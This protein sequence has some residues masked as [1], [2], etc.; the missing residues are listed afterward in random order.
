[1][2]IFVTCSDPKFIIYL[3]K[4]KYENEDLIKY[5]LPTDIWFHV[6]KFSSAHVYLRLPP[7]VTIDKIPKQVMSECL[8][9]VKDGSKDGRKQEKVSVVYTPWYNL[10]KTQGMEIGEVGFKNEKDVHHIQNVTK[11]KDLL[12]KLMRTWV[13]KEVDLAAERKAYD[14]EEKNKQI[15]KRDEQKKKEKE[16]AKKY[17]EELKE[18][19]FEY[20]DEIGKEQTNKNQTEDLEEDFM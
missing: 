18:K 20:I 8:Q 15:K 6:D 7:D 1:M 12:K 11:D 3:G 10:K 17:K 9:L 16:D 2:V 14:L 13:E 19:R 5:G 4:D